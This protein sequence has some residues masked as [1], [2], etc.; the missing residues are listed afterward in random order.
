MKE[1]FDML[2]LPFGA[3]LNLNIPEQTLEKVF[4]E[5]TKDKLEITEFHCMEGYFSFYA[6]KGILPRMNIQIGIQEITLNREQCILLLSDNK[7]NILK[8]ID[9]LSIVGIKLPLKPH[10]DNLMHLDL[11]QSWLQK[12]KGQPKALLTI[13][14]TL[15]VNVEIIPAFMRVKLKTYQV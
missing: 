13:L 11:S 15:K 14:D 8:L 5:Y 2:S 3:E 9:I 10:H 4:Q 12:M 7:G 6:K 1:L